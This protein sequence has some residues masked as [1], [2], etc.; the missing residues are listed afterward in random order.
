MDSGTEVAEIPQT[1]LPEKSVEFR[2]FS[3]ATAP[4]LEK[5]TN[6]PAMAHLDGNRS[7]M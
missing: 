1:A 4:R 7:M 2:Y 6:R 3:T 5:T